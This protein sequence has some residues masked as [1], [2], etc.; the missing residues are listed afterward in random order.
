MAPPTQENYGATPT[1]ELTKV[2][3]PRTRTPWDS[4]AWITATLLDEQGQRCPCPPGCAGDCAVRSHWLFNEKDNDLRTI[5]TLQST[6]N[7]P[8]VS[9]NAGNVA[10]WGKVAQ[11]NA[12]SYRVMGGCPPSDQMDCIACDTGAGYYPV[13]YAGDFSIEGI[14]QTGAGISCYYLEICENDDSCDTQIAMSEVG[15]L[16]GS[17]AG[18]FSF[19]LILFVMLRKIVW[20]RMAIDS[21]AW[22]EKG[23][24]KYPPR[25]I[26]LPK[27]REDSAW[28]WLYDAY[29]RDNNWMKEFTTPDEYM[30]VRWF[31]LSSR[32]FFAAGAVCCP[33]LMSLYAA[34]TVPSVDAG[35]KIL[36]T[37]EKSGIAKY[38]LLNARTESS[39]AAAMAF[40]WIT[41]LFLISLIRVESRKYV[42][43]MWTVDPD[44]TGIKANAI[45]VKDMPLLTTA[46]APKK[47]E[48][49]NTGSVKDIL[50]VKK[51]VRGSVKKLDKIFDDEEVGCL[52]RFKLL[53]NDGTVQSSGDSAKLR[54]LYKEESMNLLISKFESVLG[55]D[56]IAF[57]MLASDTRKLDSAAKAWANAR[58]HVTQNMQA[59]ADLQ[60]TEK[61]GATQLGGIDS[62]CE[63][64][65]RYGFVEESRGATLRCFH[66]HSR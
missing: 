44:K 15:T 28:S 31:K 64:V 24:P 7:P 47:F 16:V 48:Q 10:P 30:L 58:E 45:L 41:S 51:S 61:T 19:L 17:Y 36:T 46:P 50:K 26:Q 11:V 25:E 9:L 62:T 14:K 27:P 57:K 52:G 43:M 6:S 59:I 35:S 63:S 12:S 22:V 55:K 5:H 60:E 1:S 8:R 38:T 2:Q 37:L 4:A 3:P 53:L 49:L 39:F 66:L 56:C 32:F 23:N 42:H 13:V 40:T 21:A 29:H 33:I 65:E 20:L 18:L 54:L 34:D